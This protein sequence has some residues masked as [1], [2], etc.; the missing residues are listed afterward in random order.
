MSEASVQLYNKIVSVVGDGQLTPA[1]ITGIII[2]MMQM[3]ED[4]TFGLSGIEKKDLVVEVINRYIDSE[5]KEAH[6]QAV[7]KILTQSTIPPLIDSLVGLSRG[8]IV[9][10]GKKCIKRLLCC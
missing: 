8:D 5:I 4:P 2:A 6:A 9:I 1:N 7:L 3:V 10:K